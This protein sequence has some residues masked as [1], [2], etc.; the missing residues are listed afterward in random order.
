MFGALLAMASTRSTDLWELAARMPA[1]VAAFARRQ[2]Q[3]KIAL[4]IRAVLAH[5]RDSGFVS[6]DEDFFDFILRICVSGF[7]LLRPK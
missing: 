7:I 3:I 4:K 6:R 5:E 1:N 2:P